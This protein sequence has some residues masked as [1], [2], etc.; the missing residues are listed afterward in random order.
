MDDAVFIVGF[1]SSTTS[2]YDPE[3]TI[4]TINPFGGQDLFLLKIDV[5]G[6]FDWVHGMGSSQNDQVTAIDKDSNNNIIIAGS[7]YGLID[8]DPSATSSTLL[9]SSD[10]QDSFIAMYDINGTILKATSIGGIGSDY[11]NDLVFDGATNDI[12]FGGYFNNDISFGGI[13]ENSQGASDLFW[14]NSI[15]T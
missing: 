13:N 2:V 8:M 15:R 6:N 3:G 12:S 10:A 1:Y 9:T 11:I 4:A 14:G 7:F 5:N